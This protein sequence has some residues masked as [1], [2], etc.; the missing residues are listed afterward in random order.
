MTTPQLASSSGGLPSAVLWAQLMMRDRLRSGNVAIDA[1]LGNGHDTLFL[2]RIVGAEGHVHGFDIQSA[3][4]NE[5][6]NRLCMAEISPEQFTLHE[7]SHSRMAEAIDDPH[8][9]RVRGVMFNLGYLPGGDKSVITETGETMIAI[10]LALEILQPGGLLTVV[11]YPGHEGGAQEGRT[12][13]DWAAG[14]S[15]RSVEVQNLRPVNR[16]AAPPECWAFWK[17]PI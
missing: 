12:L 8:R 10:E 6:R 4:V 11:V 17:R 16:A 15:P 9:S 14:L 1:T 13:A 3:A 2:A 7:M 5:T